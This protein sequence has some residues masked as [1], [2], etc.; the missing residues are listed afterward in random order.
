M[1]ITVEYA[2]CVSWGV[3]VDYCTLKKMTTVIDAT[4]LTIAYSKMQTILNNNKLGYLQDNS[5]V[6]R[7]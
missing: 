3:Y 7:K 6:K 5:Q 2:V 4:V 1:Q